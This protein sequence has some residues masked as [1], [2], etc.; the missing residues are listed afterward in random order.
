MS[1]LAVTNAMKTTVKRTHLSSSLIQRLIIISVT[2]NR[3][4]GGAQWR[5]HDIPLIAMLP[6]FD[7]RSGLSLLL[8]LLLAAR[9]FHLL[10]R[11]VQSRVKVTQ[12]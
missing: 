5:E 9:D 1:D 6:G 2:H 10:G 3:G 12:G 7:C 11:V 8:V 4:A